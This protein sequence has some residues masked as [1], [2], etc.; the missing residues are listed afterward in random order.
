MDSIDAPSFYW[1]GEEP[2]LELRRKK[3]SNTMKRKFADIFTA[4]YRKENTKA[5]KL[6]EGIKLDRSD[7]YMQGYLSSVAAMLKAREANDGRYFIA[8][9]G[10]TKQDFIKARDL[11]QDTKRTHIFSES[12]MGYIGA[13]LDYLDTI[14][15]S[16][17][18]P[19]KKELEDGREEYPNEEPGE[20]ETSNTL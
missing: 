11:L 10:D 17:Q 20:E 12:D 3:E 8:S 2:R 15:D 4:I 7:R 1:S 5:G 18:L 13:W 19:S 9:I 6:L 16:N 14:I